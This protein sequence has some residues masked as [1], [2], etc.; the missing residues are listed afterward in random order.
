VARG[1]L[2]IRTGDVQQARE[3]LLHAAA[4]APTDATRR[5]LRH[6]AEQIARQ[7]LD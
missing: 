2:L 7:Q 6:R 3:V 5:H 4:L 1:E